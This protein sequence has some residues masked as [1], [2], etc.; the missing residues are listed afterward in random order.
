ME[1]ARRGAPEG[2]TIV[3]REQTAG[4]GRLGR[5]WRS[6]LDAGLYLS[7][8]LRPRLALADFPI[9]VFAAA[10]AVHDALLEACALTTDIKYP[11]DL[12]YGTEKLCGILGE[13]L[14]TSSGTAA[15]IGI[16]INLTNEGVAHDLPHATSLEAA[17]GKSFTAHV[18]MR[19]VLEAFA[20]RYAALHETDGIQHTLAAWC[21]ASSFANGKRVHINLDYETF[22]GTTRGL[23]SDGALRVETQDGQI[24]LVRAGDVTAVRA[25]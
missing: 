8:V 10:R 21:A 3:A 9:L 2:T 12:L 15:I 16:G 7:L 11:N 22:V 5:A 6:P 24:K 20:A 13:T 17:T 1:Q 25:R 14:D 19:V 18:I 23:A 4:R